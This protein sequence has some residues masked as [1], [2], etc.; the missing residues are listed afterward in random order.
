MPRDGVL[1]TQ[2]ADVAQLVEHH[3]AKVRVAGSNPVVRS[4][5]AWSYCGSSDSGGDTPL[6][7]RS[8][9]K[10]PTVTRPGWLTVA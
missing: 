3:L 2:Q 9:S 6:L 10:S 5:N 7:Q 4:K 1:C 8:S